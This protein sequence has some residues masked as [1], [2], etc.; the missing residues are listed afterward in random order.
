MPISAESGFQSGIQKIENLVEEIERF[1][2]PNVRAKAKE[3]V[4]SVMDLHGAGIGRMMEIIM[5]GG[6][7]GIADAMAG[8]DLVNNLLLLYGL[9]P[10]SLEERVLKSLDKVRPYLKSH[11]GNVEIIS[12]DEGRGAVR[13]RLQGSCKS[14]P[15]SAMTL[16]LAIEEAIYG[17]CPDVTAI[18]A[19]GVVERPS[20][21]GVVS[22]KGK[23]SN[24]R[25]SEQSAPK[26]KE[27]GEWEEVRGIDSL[28]HGS[29]KVIEVAGRLVLFCRLGE[30]YYAYESRCPGC[31]EA[32]AG[33]RL[34]TTSLTCKACSTQFDIIRAGRGLDQPGIHLEPFPLLVEGNQAKIALPAM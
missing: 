32:L 19:E 2:D 1:P 6:G 16:K 28:A 33:G 21:S 25:V 24:N 23:I 12:V 15:S 27:L 13:L 8:D 17:Y 11:G 34:D 29:A 20:P 5:D 31:G 18:E 14:C 10:L 3:L 26:G 30:T 7:D 9:H 4:Q 22:F